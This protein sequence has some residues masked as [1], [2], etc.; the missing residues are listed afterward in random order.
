M[1]ATDIATY[2]LNWPRGRFSE[3]QSSKMQDSVVKNSIL[4]NSEE[5]PRVVQ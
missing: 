3:K 1:C 2:R 5:H 4:H